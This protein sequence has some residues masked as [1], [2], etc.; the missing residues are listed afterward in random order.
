MKGSHT[1]TH[2]F[3]DLLIFQVKSLLLTMEIIRE[4][5]PHK[6]TCVWVGLC[7]C[8][9]YLYALTCLLVYCLL[10]V[11]FMMYCMMTC[12]HCSQITLGHELCS[13]HSCDVNMLQQ[14]HGDLSAENQTWRSVSL[15]QCTMVALHSIIVTTHK[16]NGYIW[17]LAA[18]TYL[19]C[20]V[21]ILVTVSYDCSPLLSFV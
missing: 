21:N 5:G 14:H 16:P 15:A 4:W 13:A 2:T 19:H 1:H 3:L 10:Y 20:F 6:G 8:L 18:E 7:T 17:H 11:C 12:K 9:L